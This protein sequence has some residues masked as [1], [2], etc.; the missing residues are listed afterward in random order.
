[1]PKARC[2]AKPITTIPE[3]RSTMRIAPPTRTG[4]ECSS[5]SGKEWGRNGWIIASSNAHGMITDDVMLCE[6]SRYNKRTK[7]WMKKRT[8]RHL[9]YDFTY[10]TQGNWTRLNYYLD[11][12]K[13]YTCIREIEYY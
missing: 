3:E 8:L 13:S 2:A 4:A 5:P 11:G 9:T 10:D 12:K 7:R 1:M 6:H